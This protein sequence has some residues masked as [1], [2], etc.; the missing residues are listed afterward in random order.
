MEVWKDIKGYEGYYRLSNNGVLFGIKRGKYYNGDELPDGYL[1]FGF[2]KPNQRPKTVRVNRIVYQ[3]FVGEIPKGYDV[4]HINHNP[5]DNRVENL[6]LIEIHKHH[7]LH[8]RDYYKP[9]SQ[10]SKKGKHIANYK[11]IT[12]A[13]KQTG[14]NINRISA[15][16]NGKTKTAGGFIWV[17]QGNEDIK[18]VVNNVIQKK[19]KPIIQLTLDGEFVAEYPSA[20]EAERKTGI[21]NANISRCCKNIYGFKSAG[22]YK[23]R[24][25]YE[26]Q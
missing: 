17:N 3:T 4:H 11:S 2:S 9:V 16:L 21:N 15:C 22:G 1:V 26:L 10:Y 12:D 19:G 13:S 8:S 24:F 23:W 18:S 6:E 7:L 25:K 14:I 20:L 5:K